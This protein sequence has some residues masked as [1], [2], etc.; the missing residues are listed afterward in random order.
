MRGKSDRKGGSVRIYLFLSVFLFT[1]LLFFSTFTPTAQA[2]GYGDLTEDGSVDV[3]DVVMVMRHVLELDLLPQDLQVAADVNGDGRVDVN[4]VVIIMRYALGLIDEFPVPFVIT[5]VADAVDINVS[6]GTAYAAIPFP[7][8][9]EVTFHDNKTRMLEVTWAAA[10]DAKPAYNAQQVGT[11]RF[12][13]VIELPVHVDNP[14]ELTASV[15]VIISDDEA[16]DDPY[17]WPEQL[18]RPPVISYIDLAN[19]YAV[20]ITIKS[21]Y[22]DLVEGVVILGEDAV[23][24]H[25]N[26]ERWR[27]AFEDEPTLADLEGKI[28]VVLKD[29]DNGDD[30][31]E[32]DAIDADRSRA[33]YIGILDDTKVVVYIKYGKD[34]DAVTAADTALTYNTDD[35]YWEATL[36][37][38]EA[39]DEVEVTATAGQ[40]EQTVVLVVVAVE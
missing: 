22:K 36:Y 1:V 19:A 2:V 27:A 6:P 10:A 37:G 21:E 20:T 7:E 3:R 34:V 15:N 29:N 31:V 25:N 17:E 8:Q 38:Y 30:D 24:D 12:D 9:V 26:P 13:G 23:Q 14:D 28:V 16:N 33:V 5:A 18:D 35:D 11:Y 39:G 40:N 4:D 32:L